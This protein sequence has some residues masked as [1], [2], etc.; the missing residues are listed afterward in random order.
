NVSQV[1]TY[2]G[3]TH[4]CTDKEYL[5]GMGYFVSMTICDPID[6]ATYDTYTS[7]TVY[8]ASASYDVRVSAGEGGS[9]SGGGSFVVG[10]TATVTAEAAEEYTFAGWYDAAGEKVSDSAVY[11]FTVT[12]SV[13]LTARFEKDEET[14]PEGAFTDVKP[15]DWYADAVAY[16][17]ENGLF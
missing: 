17:V 4:R 7:E 15:T 2:D 12:A 13:S 16:A 5:P 14:Q 3:A 1:G 8:P 11:T 6:G 10:S 9:V